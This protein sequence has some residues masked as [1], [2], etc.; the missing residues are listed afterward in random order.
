MKSNGQMVVPVDGELLIIDKVGNPPMQ[1]FLRQ[2][3]QEFGPHGARVL[4]SYLPF[5]I[6][7]PSF[8]NGH[9]P[10][11][12]VVVD[13]SRNALRT[14][15]RTEHRR[16][17]ILAS[18]IPRPDAT[19]TPP[20]S[21]ISSTARVYASAFQRVVMSVDSSQGRSKIPAPDVAGAR[22]PR[23]ESASPQHMREC[24]GK[25]RGPEVAPGTS[26]KPQKEAASSENDDLQGWIPLV[27]AL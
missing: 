11:G 26:E 4:C 2:C 17:S 27:C 22:H 15:P 20:R 18:K 9:F 1:E 16:Q 19:A 14:P 13:P 8:E 24:Q 6:L 3:V 12:V 21:G 10:G 23:R 5:K 7:K 25:N